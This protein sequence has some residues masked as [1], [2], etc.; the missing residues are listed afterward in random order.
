MQVF[1]PKFTDLF[2]NTSRDE[3]VFDNDASGADL[4]IMKFDNNPYNKLEDMDGYDNLPKFV[5]D[6]LHK[7]PVYST[8][9]VEGWN[10]IEFENQRLVDMFGSDVIYTPPDDKNAIF[11]KSLEQWFEGLPYGNDQLGHTDAEDDFQLNETKSYGL[12]SSLLDIFGDKEV[13]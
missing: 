5:Q 12:T 6:M 13:K 3:W 9:E 4:R 8:S 2:R 7:S 11:Y 10:R 1:D